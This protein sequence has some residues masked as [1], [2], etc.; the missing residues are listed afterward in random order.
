MCDFFAEEWW[1]ARIFPS[2]PSTR[3]AAEH[4]VSHQ[5]LPEKARVVVGPGL[6]A[7][8]V[9]QPIVRAHKGL[10]E[11]AGDTLAGRSPSWSSHQ[12]E[13]RYVSDRPG[14]PP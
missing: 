14:S 4:H 11:H 12:I 7:V 9:E 3:G 13:E 1:Y 10:A 8:L 6:E 2:C 5:P